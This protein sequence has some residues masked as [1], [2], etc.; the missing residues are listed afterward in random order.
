MFLATTL[1]IET[2]RFFM[3]RQKE[4]PVLWIF[5]FD[6]RRKCKHVNFIDRTDG[7]VSG[8]DEFLFCPYSA[9]AIADVTW[10]N[11]PDADSPHEIRLLV[12]PDNMTVS[13]D[14][15]LSPWN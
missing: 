14:L 7:T 8:E 15:P 13:E 6:S 4:D 3:R 1:T 12:C 9:F 11:Q 5:E 10:R 2:T